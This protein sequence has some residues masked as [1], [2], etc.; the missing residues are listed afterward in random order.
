[1]IYK[2]ITIGCPPENCTEYL[3]RLFHETPWSSIK[4][5]LPD[6][7]REASHLHSLH[8]MATSVLRC[9]VV[10]YYQEVFAQESNDAN[11]DRL[12]SCEEWQ[13]VA[14]DHLCRFA[15]CNYA[16][17]SEQKQLHATLKAFREMEGD[18]T[19]G[20]V[21]GADTFEHYLFHSQ[22]YFFQVCEQK[23]EYLSKYIGYELSRKVYGRTKHQ[24]IRPAHP[25]PVRP[26]R[27][28][29]K[30][31][32]VLQAEHALQDTAQAAAR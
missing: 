20:Y 13:C 7:Y 21:K 25:K 4:E 32:C 6:V 15:R 5:L 19:T 30:P 28:K 1:M 22:R 26:P 27:R 3:N 23:A 10:Q 11:P 14:F 24:T 18:P 29:R 12:L 8:S 9:G 17:R 16:Q 2:G 31:L